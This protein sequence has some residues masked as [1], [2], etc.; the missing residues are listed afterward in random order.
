MMTTDPLRRARQKKN[1][2]QKIKN[3]GG[4]L[5]ASPDWLTDGEINAGVIRQ[6]G[7]D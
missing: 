2:P 6:E 3:R 7:R 5:S 1:V 4:K